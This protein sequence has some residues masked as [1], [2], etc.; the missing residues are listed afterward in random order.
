MGELANMIG[1]NLKSVLPKG[2]T[3]S[4]PCVMEGKNYSFHVC[5]VNESFKIAFGG[6]H[7]TFWVTIFTYVK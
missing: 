3:L 1:G 6:A 4:L 2:V 7:G 5:K